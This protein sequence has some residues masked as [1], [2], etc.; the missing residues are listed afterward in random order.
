MRLILSGL[1]LITAMASYGQ[2]KMVGTWYTVSDEDGKPKSHVEIYEVNGKL[3]GKVV[4]LLPAATLTH[5]NEC[6]GDLKDKPI[7]GM[8]ILWGL[9]KDSET[10]YEDGEILDPKSGKIY[11]CFIELES[12]DKLKVRGYLGISLLGRTQYWYKVK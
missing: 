7:E 1:F 5:C 11:S 3:E 8:K 9:E 6:E 4:K 10:L 12:A 2:S